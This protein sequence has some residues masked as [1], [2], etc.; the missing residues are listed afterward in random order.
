GFE[1]A[2]KALRKG[3]IRTQAEMATALLTKLGSNR[4]RLVGLAYSAA[5]DALYS[6]V[7]DD[8]GVVHDIAA[9]DAGRLTVLPVDDRTEGAR[10]RIALDRPIQL[11]T[12]GYAVAIVTPVRAERASSMPARVTVVDPQS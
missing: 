1:A 10:E 5:K 7:V 4:T 2:M 3:G 9:W 11:A 6:L 8:D 12:V